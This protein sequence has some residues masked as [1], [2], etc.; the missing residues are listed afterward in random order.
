MSD[1]HYEKYEMTDP[2][3]PPPKHIMGFSFIRH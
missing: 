2:F 3:D 1:K